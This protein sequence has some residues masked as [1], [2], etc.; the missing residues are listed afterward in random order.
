MPTVK[1]A[2]M[3]PHDLV[4]SFRQ[5]ANLLAELGYD[6]DAADLREQAKA[7]ADLLIKQ[8]VLLEQIELLHEAIQTHKRQSSRAAIRKDRA[9]EA[10]S[11]LGLWA[12]LNNREQQ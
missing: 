2:A 7:I 3:T 6:S 11:N 9:A 1:A 8:R 12:A 4:Y 10:I 5:Q